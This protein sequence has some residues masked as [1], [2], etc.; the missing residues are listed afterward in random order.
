MYPADIISMPD[1][2]QYPWYASWDPTFDVP[3]P[4]LAE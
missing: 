4:T 1:T 3:A 2:W